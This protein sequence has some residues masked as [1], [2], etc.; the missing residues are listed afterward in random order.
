MGT[1]WA[2]EPQCTITEREIAIMSADK[3]HALL[4][5]VKR[6]F[7]EKKMDRRE[8]VRYATLLGMSSAAAYSASPPTF[9]LTVA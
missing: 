6:Q 5:D 8:F 4:P 3:E 2:N 1:S 7:A 9:P